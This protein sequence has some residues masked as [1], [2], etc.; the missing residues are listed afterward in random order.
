M[1]RDPRLTRVQLLRA[2]RSRKQRWPDPEFV[3]AHWWRGP[4]HVLRGIPRTNILS[5]PDGTTTAYDV[6]LSWARTINDDDLDPTQFPK[7]TGGANGPVCQ[8]GSSQCHI[9]L[10]LHADIWRYGK[11]Y[12]MGLRARDSAPPRSC[13][14]NSNWHQ[15]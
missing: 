12:S 4:M 5:R 9:L 14:G 8:D 3:L 13:K 2:I 11:L 10:H 7:A 15:Q 6:G 1:M